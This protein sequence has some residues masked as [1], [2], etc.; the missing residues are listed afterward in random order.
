MIQRSQILGKIKKM[1]ETTDQIWATAQSGL[2]KKVIATVGGV[3]SYI[4][5][6][7]HFYFCRRLPSLEKHFQTKNVFAGFEKTAG[8]QPQC[9]FRIRVLPNHLNIGP[10]R[11][12]HR[13]SDYESLLRN[14]IT[15]W[16]IIVL[17]RYPRGFQNSYVTIKHHHHWITTVFTTFTPVM[18]GIPL[19]T[20]NQ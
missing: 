3:A 2:A 16:F 4:F 14:L 17:P 15:A 7:Q 18:A 10:T 1:F 20:R 8:W 11:V 12:K 9:H 19:T 13:Q 5:A 6:H